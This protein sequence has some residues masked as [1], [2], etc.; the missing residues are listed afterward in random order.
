L[1]P[2]GRYLVNIAATSRKYRADSLGK[3]EPLPL[4]DWLD[5]GVYARNSKDEDSLIYLKKVKVNAQQT[6]FSIVVDKEPSTAGIDPLYKQI[7]RNTF[8]NRKIIKKKS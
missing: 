6:F 8:D 4:N 7:D 2:E 1:K 5:L 3:Q